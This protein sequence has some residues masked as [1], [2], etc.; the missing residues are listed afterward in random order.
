MRIYRDIRFSKDKTPYKTRIGIIFWEGPGKKMLHSGFHLGF[1]DDMLVVHGGM[2]G[3][4][5]EMLPKYRAAVVADKSGKDLEKIVTKLKESGYSIGGVHYKK[6]P[7]GFD[8]E[9]ERANFLLH[10][11]LYAGFSKIP[12]K[13]LKSPELVDH[14]F[15]HFK[16]MSPLHNWLVERDLS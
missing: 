1:S 7:R 12:R 14:C 4:T 3:F 10:N 16:I 6:V 2:H 11:G 15:E 5:K 13:A 8:P 9:H